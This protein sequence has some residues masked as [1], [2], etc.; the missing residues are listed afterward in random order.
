MCGGGV[1]EVYGEVDVVNS[2]LC[3]AFSAFFWSW[4]PESR[5]VLTP[6]FLFLC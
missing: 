1:N 2:A 5:P 4:T 3:I 6:R